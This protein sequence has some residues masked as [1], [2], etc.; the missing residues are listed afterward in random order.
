MKIRLSIIV[1]THN[2]PESLRRCIESI[3]ASTVPDKH[4][5]IVIVNGTEDKTPDLPAS[6]SSGVLNMRHYVISRTS[7]GEARNE[8]IKRAL[9]EILYFL[10][11]DVITGKD[12][13]MEAL[14]IFDRRA[15]VDIAGGPNLTPPGNT[16]FQKCI[17][18]ALA[19]PFGSAGMRR[20]YIVL[21]AETL[22][23]DSALILCNLAIR[24]RAL[25]LEGA[26][27]DK[28]IVCNEENILLQRMRTKGHKMLY[29]PRLAVYHD[30]RKDLFEF[31]RQ[32]FK[33]G[34]GRMQQTLRMPASTPPFVFLPAIFA[35]YLL[36]LLL[37][38]SGPYLV[39]LYV[40]MALDIFFSLEIS[41]KGRDI[42]LAPISACVFPVLH[43]SYGAGF[44]YAF[45]RRCTER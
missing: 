7:N 40:Y 26:L 16:P 9:G 3:S 32:V 19:S 33:Y 10:D 30:R 20:R 18:H 43:L 17:G 8:G 44:I 11:D 14:R 41:L 1:I 42:L 24:R 13:F 37:A 35:L 28:K 5:L 29:S 25:E 4:E 34:R 21:P 39:P 27:F 15:D 36:S 31:A 12:I 6:A 22:V 38:H 23:D 2:R 45:F